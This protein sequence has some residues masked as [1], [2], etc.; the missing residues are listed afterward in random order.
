MNSAD[1]RRRSF[2][3]GTLAAV[4]TTAALWTPASQADE[5][6][7][8]AVTLVSP[9]GAGGAA[10]LAARTLANHASATL[11]QEIVV[12]IKAGAAGVTGSNFVARARPDGY[13]MLLARVG[14]QSA[15]PAMNK[16]IPYQWDDFSFIGLIEKN[17]FSLTVSA[18]SPYKSLDDIKAAVA[19]GKKLTY[20]SAGVGALQHV[21]MVVLLDKLGLDQASM[22]HVPFKGGGAANSAVLGGHVDIFFQN[23]SGVIGNI[24]AG[25]LRSLAVTTEERVPTL[26]DVPTFAELGLPGMNVVVGWSAIYG[27]KNLPDA[28]MKKWV[29]TLATVSKD[30]AWIDAT[31]KLGSVPAVMSPDD[32]KTFVKQQYETFGEIAERLG[33]MIK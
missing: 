28:V 27:P 11:G 7:S 14:S 19:A 24:Q 26:P 3:I 33:L 21:G 23:L 5:Y 12:V 29:Q 6:P 25:K 22:S 15:V 30:K 17:P 10:D 4:A 16:T 13:N 18:D 20:S 9:Y 2:V 31:R 8:R 1:N 32:T